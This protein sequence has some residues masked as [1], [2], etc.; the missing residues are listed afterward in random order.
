MNAHWELP[1][2][3]HIRACVLAAVWLTRDRRTPHSP[4]RPKSSRCE[5]RRVKHSDTFRPPSA[6]RL[7]QLSW[8]APRYRLRRRGRN[9]RVGLRWQP[10]R[11]ECTESS[12]LRLQLREEDH[13]A[14]AFLAEEHHAKAIN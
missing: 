5:N 7:R 4:S 6:V 14:D 10:R 11:C 13:V 2:M 3:D 8:L 9:R 1:T 12:S